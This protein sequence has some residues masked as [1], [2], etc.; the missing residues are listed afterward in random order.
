MRSDKAL[1]NAFRR[2]QLP[3]ADDPRA[4]V[5]MLVAALP[6]E[7]RRRWDALEFDNA[8]RVAFA[9]QNPRYAHLLTA[10]F[11]C[12][13][14][15]EELEWILAQFERGLPDGDVL[16]IGAGAGV[17]AAVTALATKRSVAACDPAVGSAA[18]VAHVADAVGVQVRAIESS[19]ANL[20]VDVLDNTTTVVAQ[21]VLAHFEFEAKCDC[22]AAERSALLTAISAAGEALVIEH[23]TNVLLDASSASWQSF[24][25]AMSD[26]GMYPVWDT[27]S[28]VRGYNALTPDVPAYERPMFARPKLCLRFSKS[29]D[30]RG[31]E[32]RLESI[33][34]ENPL[35]SGWT[36]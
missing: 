5:G 10:G 23:T 35:G 9:Y 2:L 14:F 21:S 34:S 1:R 28:I 17:T 16:D 25:A 22:E 4:V 36:A 32:R 3:T 33:L 12:P 6:L 13:T 18:A 11:T 29:G 15:R 24:A 7:I 20:P 31:T 19:C 8:G 30:P 27:A 26:M